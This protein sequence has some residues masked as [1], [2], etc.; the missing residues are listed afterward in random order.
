MKSLHTSLVALAATGLFA[1]GCGGS[2]EGAAVTTAETAPAPTGEVL[3]V[4]GK[5]YT[6]EPAGLTAAP[7]TFTVEFANQGIIEH[8]FTIEGTD[9]AIA[10]AA[11]ETASGTVSLEAGTYKVLCTVAGHEAAGMV[12]TLT[13]G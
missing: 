10:T 13:V 2:P 1:V 3:S 5:E 9:L 12:A 11:G 7:G 8:N 6:F 4:I